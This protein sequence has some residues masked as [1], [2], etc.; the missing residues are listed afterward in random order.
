MGTGKPKKALSFSGL[1][2]RRMM[3]YVNAI[4]MGF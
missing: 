4:E 1:N 2:S 3:H